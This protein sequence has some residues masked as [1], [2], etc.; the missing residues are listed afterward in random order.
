MLSLSKFFRGPS[1]R[2][3]LLVGKG[4]TFDRR[5]AVPAPL[6]GLPTLGLNHVCRQMPCTLT[7]FTDLDAYRQCAETLAA[8]DGAVAMPWFPHVDNKPGKKTV[9]ELH[10]EIPELEAL[11]MQNRLFVYNSSLDR[12]RRI[13]LSTHRVKFFSA[14]VGLDILCVHGVEIVFTLGVDGGK[15]YAKGFD[16]ATL[17]SNGRPSFDVQFSEMKK[18]ADRYKVDVRPIF[19]R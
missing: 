4:P 16:P 9:D 5:D 6:K 12:R 15:A 11:R 13:G 10:D 14:V 17:L 7:H 19:P 2:A 8:Q 3:W 1:A 18:I